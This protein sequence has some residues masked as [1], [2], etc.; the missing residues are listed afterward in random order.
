MFGLDQL[1]TTNTEALTN[2]PLEKR[3]TIAGG[4]PDE[5]KIKAIATL[6]YPEEKKTGVC[7]YGIRFC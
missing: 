1:L 7:Q 4:L 2:L 6:A 3:A 5:L